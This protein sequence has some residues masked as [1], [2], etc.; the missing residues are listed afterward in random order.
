MQHKLRNCLISMIAAFVVLCWGVSTQAE[1]SGTTKTTTATP[2]SNATIKKATASTG[3]ATTKTTATNPGK[4]ASVNGTVI[5]QVQ[6]DSALAYQQ[7]IA[8]L[9][10][11]T[12][13]DEQMPELKYQLVQNL[14]GTELLYQE[15]Q[16][17]GIKVEEKE[18]NESYEAQKQKAQFKT[19]AEFEEA[20]KKSKKSMTSYRAEIKQGLAIDHFVK[21]KFTDKTTVSDSE[22]KKYYD[23]N[24]SYFQQPAQV[25]ASHIMIKIDSKADQA[26]K[27]EA[28]KKIE[29][30]LKRVKAGEDFA[31]V[32]KE[33]SEDANSKAN[34]GDLNYFSKGQTPKSFED[35]AFALKTGEISDIVT[36]D[37]G[38]HI[39]KATD[40]KDAKKISYEEAKNDIIS[41]LKSSKVNSAVN[42]YI[43]ALKNKSTIETFP[44]SK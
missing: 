25:R 13:T 24:P 41:N 6:F 39:I 4:V 7:E 9:N 35:A 43:T 19:D 10:R 18:I 5:S 23:D 14:I 28:R 44:I 3:A 37:T 29:Q 15:S 8:A 33:A 20:L 27:D 17:S 36:T 34:G 22:A 12:I 1:D 32:A 42:K 26:K 30:A 31:A 21:T 2:A 16:K 11:M 38:Y 40:K